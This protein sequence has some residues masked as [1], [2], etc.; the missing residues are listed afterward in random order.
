MKKFIK[1]N[2][3]KV[4]IIIFISFLIVCV[5]CLFF[6]INNQKKRQVKLQVK[7][8]V[9]TLLLENKVKILE[10]KIKNIETDQSIED[11]FDSKLV[12]PYTASFQD[13]NDNLS[14][15]IEDIKEYGAGTKISFSILNESSITYKDLSL[16]FQ[17][18][19]SWSGKNFNAL[20]YADYEFINKISSGFTRK[21]EI[22]FSDV[23]MDEIKVL[24]ITQ[25]EAILEFYKH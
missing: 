20:G 2:W 9:D 17:A 1:K 7:L 15:S 3:F 13:I 14:I 25:G 4:I 19:D 16:K 18:R 5:I 22:I 23:K 6:K 21:G 24:K 12:D 10:D 8:S 11:I